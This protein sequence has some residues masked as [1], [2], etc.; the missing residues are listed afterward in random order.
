[1]LDWTNQIIHNNLPSKSVENMMLNNI[2]GV[3]IIISVCLIVSG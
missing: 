2:L 3:N 1:M